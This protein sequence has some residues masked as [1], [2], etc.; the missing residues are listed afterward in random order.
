MGGECLPFKLQRQSEP[1]YRAV[2]DLEKNW[3]D[4]LGVSWIFPI[5]TSAECSN[6]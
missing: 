1:R 5:A 6:L 3:A 2:A 4:L